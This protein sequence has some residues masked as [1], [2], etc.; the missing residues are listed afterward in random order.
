[1]AYHM[2]NAFTYEITDFTTQTTGQ[3]VIRLCELTCRALVVPDLQEVSQNFKVFPK[4]QRLVEGR[5][6]SRAK[7]NW[8]QADGQIINGHFVLVAVSRDSAEV[9]EEKSHCVLGVEANK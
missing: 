6:W 7:E 5:S 3:S 9:V 4:V 1:M 2:N 8:P